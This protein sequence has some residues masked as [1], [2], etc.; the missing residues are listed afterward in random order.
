MRALVLGAGSVGVYFGGRLAQSGA[1]VSVVARSDYDVAVRS[2]YE[3]ASIA[4]NFHF[5]PKFVLKDG[6]D[7]K[8]VE[9]AIKSM[10]DYFADYDTTVHFISAEELKEKHSGLPHGGFV[11]RTGK[12]GF[13]LEN[14]H[15]VEY[16]LKLDSNPEFTG[17][18]LVALARAADRMSKRGETGCRTI[19]DI[20]PAFLS[21]LT[22]EEQRAKYL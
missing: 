5:T 20:P 7:P 13:N 2:G 21:P 17:S 15:T 12:T 10:P 9:A 3:V 8:K 16:S 18:V 4:G 6:A 11:I 1:E 19:F 14:T 22:P